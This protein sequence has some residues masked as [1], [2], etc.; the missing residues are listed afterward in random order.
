M[1][2]S[3]VWGWR[4]RPDHDTGKEV[5]NVGVEVREFVFAFRDEGLHSDF[6]TRAR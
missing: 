6:V 4:D 3:T 1:S 5:E 2:L